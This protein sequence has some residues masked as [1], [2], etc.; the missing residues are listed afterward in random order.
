MVGRLLQ[1]GVVKM[2]AAI[3]KLAITER[4]VAMAA[5]TAAKPHSTS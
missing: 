3:S 4:I 1:G 5:S 2:G